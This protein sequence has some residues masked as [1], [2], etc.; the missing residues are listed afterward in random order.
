MHSRALPEIRPQKETGDDPG[1]P[2]N[3]EK[4]TERI[5]HATGGH[6][7]CGHQAKVQENGVSHARDTSPLMLIITALFICEQ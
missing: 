5:T 7:I 4:G 3:G 6:M 2:P 1:D